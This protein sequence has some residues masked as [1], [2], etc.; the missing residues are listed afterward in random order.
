[1]PKSKSSNQSNCNIIDYLNDVDPDLALV[2]QLAC[3][4]GYLIPKGAGV[5][6]IR[7][8]PTQVT[9]LLNLVQGGPESKDKARDI[10][11]A[12]ILR[13]NLKTAADFKSNGDDIP[14]ALGHKVAVD[15][16]AT[17]GDKIVFANGATASFDKDFVDGSAARML[18]VLVLKSGAMSVE[19]EQSTK[20]KSY[21]K[22]YKKNKGKPKTD[23]AVGEGYFGGSDHYEVDQR[24]VSCEQEKNYRSK[25]FNILEADAITNFKKGEKYDNL[26]SFGLP[27]AS[28]ITGGRAMSN[29]IKDKKNMFTDAILSFLQFAKDKHPDIFSKIAPIISYEICDIVMVIE[30]GRNV[31][32]PSDYLVETGIIQE[33][34]ACIK[35][36][37]KIDNIKELIDCVDQ[38]SHELLGDCQE[39]FGTVTAQRGL[40]SPKLDD[41]KNVYRTLDSEILSKPGLSA[42]KSFYSK[43]PKIIHDE[44]RY[45]TYLK[46]AHNYDL[47]ETMSYIK[48]YFCGP[49]NSIMSNIMV[50][51]GKSANNVKHFVE[52]FYFYYLNLCEKCVGGVNGD[53]ESG[54]K[55]DYN[56]SFEGSLEDYIFINTNLKQKL[57]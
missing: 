38:K 10:L 34:V 45:T 29:S 19:G 14:D 25:L 8:T 2:F 11:R 22:N 47:A 3:G 18:S 13:M 33:W 20:I 17:T 48:Q 36:G 7:P 40:E 50:L 12:H 30:P 44:I 54:I 21:K 55:G 53:E 57:Q 39:A 16:S 41:F 32:S 43:F 28:G 51:R 1:M 27:G 9:S 52:S 5:V 15:T 56:I 24:N 26:L 31:D 37:I 46:I 49:V 42:L 35:D 23:L 6:L 4:V